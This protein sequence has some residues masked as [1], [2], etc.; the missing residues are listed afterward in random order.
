MDIAE[1]V[2]LYSQG[3]FLMDNGDG[4]AW[5][6]SKVHAVI[7]LDERFHV[8]R[9]LKRALNSG[10][11]EVRINANFPGVVEGCAYANRDATWISAELVEIYQ[12]LHQAGIAHSF[13]IWLEGELAGGILGLAIGGIFIG[14]SM[15]YYVPEASK[16]AMVKLVEHLKKRGFVLFDAQIQN[17]HLERFGAYEVSEREFLPQLRRAIT[18]VARFGE[19]LDG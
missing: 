8:P 11:F 13:E 6:R 16:V 14:E 1:I 10:R 3:Y 17:P 7:P 12:Q 9:S 5:Y 2:S 19:P 15:F 18:K 4:L